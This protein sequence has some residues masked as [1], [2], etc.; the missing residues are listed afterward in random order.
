MSGCV[1]QCGMDAGMDLGMN[2]GMN[3]GMDM[4]MNAGMN[5]G[6]DLGMD[7]GMDAGMDAGMNVRMDAGMDAGME[8]HRPDS[9]AQRG[10]GSVSHCAMT[11]SHERRPS[12]RPSGLHLQNGD[13]KHL[14]PRVPMRP[15]EPG[16]EK[17]HVTCGLL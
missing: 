6:M 7:V 11:P 13:K 5:T 2:M 4:G 10:S 15:H 8:S 1:D 17:C 16:Q 9:G 3:V 14:A 12:P